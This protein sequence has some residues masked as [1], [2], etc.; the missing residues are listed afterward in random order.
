MKHDKATSRMCIQLLVR[1]I[2]LSEGIILYTGTDL[3][4]LYPKPVPG[5]FNTVSG[6]HNYLAHVRIKQWLTYDRLYSQTECII[7]SKR[8]LL[9]KTNESEVTTSYKW[10]ES[11]SRS[12]ARPVFFECWGTVVSLHKESYQCEGTKVKLIQIQ[13]KGNCPQNKSLISKLTT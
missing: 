10:T 1:Y 9:Q 11:R 13:K 6:V 12:T 8:W 2:K 5:C 7:T 3:S 4:I